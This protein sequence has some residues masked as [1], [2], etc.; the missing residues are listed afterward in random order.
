MDARPALVE[1]GR[2][3][4]RVNYPVSDLYRVVREDDG[5]QLERSTT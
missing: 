3:L 2:Q 4:Q 5:L 1:I